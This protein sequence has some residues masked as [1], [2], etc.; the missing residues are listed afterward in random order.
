L[1]Q[2]FVKTT[3]TSTNSCFDFEITAYL[4]L[5]IIVCFYIQKLRYKIIDQED[6]I[7]KNNCVIKLLQKDIIEMQDHQNNIA[8]YRYAMF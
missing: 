3:M 2:P 6:I 4:Y 8:K 5:F 1:I 7:Y